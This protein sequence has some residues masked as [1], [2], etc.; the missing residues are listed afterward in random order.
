MAL[1]AARATA[2]D[3]TSSGQESVEVVVDFAGLSAAAD[4]LQ[5]V[6]A[7]HSLFGDQI[8][9]S[10]Q[11][12]AQ[13][14]DSPCEL[15]REALALPGCPEQQI[16]DTFKVLNQSFDSN[17]YPGETYDIPRLDIQSFTYTTVVDESSAKPFKNDPLAS[18][19][20]LVREGWK[21]FIRSVKKPTDG[22]R[23]K[24]LVELEG[25]RLR[26]HFKEMDAA[27]EAVSKFYE[28][29]LRSATIHTNV[30]APEKSKF[31]QHFVAPALQSDSCPI[32][33]GQE[34]AYWH[35]LDWLKNWELPQC[36]KECQSEGRCPQIVL[37]DQTVHPHAEL[38]SNLIHLDSAGNKRSYSR[39]EYCTNRSAVEATDQCKFGH[40]SRQCHHGTSMASVISSIHNGRGFAGLSPA[41]QIVSFDWNIAGTDDFISLIRGR[42]AAGFEDTNGP[43]IYLFASKLPE[44]VAEIRGDASAHNSSSPSYS[45]NFLNGE[46]LKD[47][48]SRHT[49]HGTVAAILASRQLWIVAAGQSDDGAPPHRL[50]ERSPFA[51]M[52]LGD[53]EHVVVVTACDKCGAP[54]ASIY[55]KANFADKDDKEF[56]TIAAPGFG[57]FT[58]REE[59]DSFAKE[60][61]GTSQAAA[62]VAGVAAAM[63][64]CGAD[65][66]IQP[67]FNGIDAAALKKRLLLTSRPL[68]PLADSQQSAPGIVD[69][70]LALLDP[71]HDWYLK[72]AQFDEADHIETKFE[73][74]CAE[75]IEFSHE[76]GE[77]GSLSTKNTLRIH[78]VPA[79]HWVDDN[80]RWYIYSSP[81]NSNGRGSVEIVGPVLLDPAFEERTL[82]KVDGGTTL[83]LGDLDDLILSRHKPWTQQCDAQ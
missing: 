63:V 40:F 45:E 39:P 33:H 54:A 48:G 31:S 52:N 14:G 3:G 77:R 23:P 55:A 27:V 21:P 50:H 69:P 66:Y 6:A 81:A 42:S 56:V 32:P 73:R 20:I 71:K 46:E 57:Y 30:A 65:Y 24:S 18:S 43:Q 82:I 4:I 76:N 16:R 13:K 1:P 70:R 47:P 64:N 22:Y 7:L 58:P 49:K 74:W 68:L 35:L 25:K 59:D 5:V 10:E 9:P 44:I 34:G 67:A 78:A 51:P 26:F 15:L 12:T 28:L 79:Q 17:L 8:I 62:F 29:E 60:H 80:R 61:G 72:R 41:N 36:A 53:N 11:V 38:K 2:N 19:E 37:V 75:R 83:K